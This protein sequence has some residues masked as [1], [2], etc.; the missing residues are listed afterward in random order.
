MSYG[1]IELTL[2]FGVVLLLGLWELFKIR[3]EIVRGREGE[4]AAETR[5][6][7]RRIPHEN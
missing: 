6:D 1:L 7:Q 4:D 3:R 2:V 5:P